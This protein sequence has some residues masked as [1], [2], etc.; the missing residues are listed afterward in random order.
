MDLPFPDSV[1]DWSWDTVES[2][3]EF[4]E[5][6][7]LEFKETIHP[8]GNTD[9]EK[10]AWRRKLEREITAFANAN[11]GV[12]VFGIR[13]S[14]GAPSPF[15]PPEH[16][17][18]QSVTNLIHNTRPVPSLEISDPIQ[19]PGVET[20]HMVLAVGIE[21]ATRKPVLTSDSAIYRRI[22]DRKEPMSR[23]QIESLFLDH[24]RKQQSIRQL[25]ME[26][27]RFYS[28]YDQHGDGFSKT[29]RAPPNY[30]LVNT[31]SLKEVLRNNTHLY[32]DSAN[33]KVI[34]AVFESLRW[35]ENEEKYYNRIISG[36]MQSPATNPD[37][38]NRNRRITLNRKLNR[39]ERDLKKL[40]EQ[41]DLQVKLVEE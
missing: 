28:S 6:Q 32:T 19:P 33:R 9:P 14:D 25:E 29:E 38:F 10:K 5:N 22:N 2:L 34:N 4:D 35:V 23:E 39:L 40:A 37:D 30:H 41:A 1:G 17:I 36:E 31:T 18:K 24:N 20:D 7:Y 15:E 26:I 21:E 12:L 16:E 3:S 27:D 8:P 13:D 11:G